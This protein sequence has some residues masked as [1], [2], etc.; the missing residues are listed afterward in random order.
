[1]HWSGSA[2]CSIVFQESFLSRMHLSPGDSTIPII[3]SHCNLKM[4]E[5]FIFLKIKGQP[6]LL[7]PF[8]L[9]NPLRTWLMRLSVLHED[10][11]SANLARPSSLSSLEKVTFEHSDSRPLPVSSFFVSS[12]IILVKGVLKRGHFE[13]GLKLDLCRNFLIGLL[14]DLFQY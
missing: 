3:R 4:T 2:G 8:S 6:V 5:T 7:Q 9:H 10:A 11:R 12:W 13:L 1:M 14:W